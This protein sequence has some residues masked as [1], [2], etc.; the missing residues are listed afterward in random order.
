MLPNWTRRRNKSLLRFGFWSSF[1]EEKKNTTPITKVEEEFHNLFPMLLL[2]VAVMMLMEL[3]TSS[4]LSLKPWRRWRL[5][6]ELMFNLMLLMELFTFSQLSLKPWRWLK[7]H[8]WTHVQSDDAHGALHIFT[9]QSKS[10]KEAKDLWLNSFFL[11][12]WCTKCI[13]NSQRKASQDD[14]KLGSLADCSFMRNRCC[15]RSSRALFF[16]GEERKS[17]TLPQSWSQSWRYLWIQS[18]RGRWEPPSC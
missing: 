15:C 7:S 1:L 2:V 8:G 10:L 12:L 9:A 4:Q 16:E 17:G 6:A 5:M 3:F 11:M 14:R 18:C 13:G